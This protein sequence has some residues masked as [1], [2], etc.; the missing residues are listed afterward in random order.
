MK[1]SGKASSAVTVVNAFAT[2]KGAAIGID[3]WTHAEVKITEEG[4]EGKIEVNGKEYHDLRV[5]KSVVDVFREYV[6]EN[7]GIK[8]RITSDIPVGRGLKSSSAAAN[9]LSV[10][11]ANALGLEIP[12]IKIV[13]LGVEAAKRAGVT[14][15]GAFDDASASYFGG[16]CITD[17]IRMELLIRRE[18]E[19]Y[20]VVLLVP[21]EIKL[22]ETLKG[23]DF[24][25]IS[26]YIEEAFKL[27]IRGEWEKATVLNGLVYSTFFSY[28]PEPISRALKLG[29]VV[30]LSGKGPTVFAVTEE[31]EKI[32]EA[33]EGL[34]NTL[35]TKIRS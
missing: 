4:I 28:N 31:P 3:L 30:G 33:W 12:D 35:V 13:K 18:L 24:S 7:F 6:N 23:I 9:A 10:A 27:A 26:P 25:V 1:G 11:I 16:L 21:S 20:P 14:L 29:A 32:I 19:A 8:F 17:N 2:G 22:T 15:T 34:G 5:V